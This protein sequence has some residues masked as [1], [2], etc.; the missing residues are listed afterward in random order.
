MGTFFGIFADIVLLMALLLQKQ[1]LS[2]IGAWNYVKT[3]PDIYQNPCFSIENKN[4]TEDDFETRNVNQ[5]VDLLGQQHEKAFIY[6]QS[7]IHEKAWYH[8]KN[9]FMAIINFY[10]KVLP[11]YMDRK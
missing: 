10:S 4:V 5:Q 7:G 8:V 6:E 1:Y 2:K 3:S 11:Q 9:F